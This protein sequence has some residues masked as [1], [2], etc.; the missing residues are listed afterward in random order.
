MFLL[1]RNENGAPELYDAVLGRDAMV[2]TL[3]RAP[4]Y[5]T[6]PA[7][8]LTTDADLR[9]RLTRFLPFELFFGLEP[10]VDFAPEEFCALLAD[11]GRYFI[12]QGDRLPLSALPL[13]EGLTQIASCAQPGG[14]APGGDLLATGRAGSSRFH[15]KKTF[16]Q[17][18]LPL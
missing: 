2:R 1:A 10:A 4:E 16:R 12:A 17:A 9:G 8:K 14:A 6:L 11:L 15:R 13:V 7:K 3:G 18:F 5:H